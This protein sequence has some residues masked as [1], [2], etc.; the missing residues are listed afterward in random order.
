MGPFLAHLTRHGYLGLSVDCQQS[1]PA[2][3]ASGCRPSAR[4]RSFLPPETIHAPNGGYR[5]RAVDYQHFVHEYFLDFAAR[6]RSAVR[7]IVPHGLVPVG[8]GWGATGALFKEG[9]EREVTLA[10]RA[11]LA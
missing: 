10:V 11:R 2:E 7:E 4:L 5:G 3:C 6:T 9:S 1:H 8:F